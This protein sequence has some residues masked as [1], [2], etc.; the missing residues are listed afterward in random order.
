MTL[1]L[2]RAG[3]RKGHEVEVA[4]KLWRQV[5]NEQKNQDLGSLS[6]QATPKATSC[7]N[8]KSTDSNQRSNHKYTPYRNPKIPEMMRS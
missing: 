3:S 8:Y 7:W 4:D 1:C 6:E 5:V 2:I